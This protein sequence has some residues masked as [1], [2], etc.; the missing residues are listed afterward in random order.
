MIAR[1]GNSGSSSG[2]HLHFQVMDRPSAL[3]SDGLPF[4]FDRFVLNGRIPPLDPAVETAINAGEQIPLNRSHAG[5]RRDEFPL[6]GD[7]L[8]F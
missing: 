2:P 5:L 4:V 3:A 6:G 8:G 1:L 7:V